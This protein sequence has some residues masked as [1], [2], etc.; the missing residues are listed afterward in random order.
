MNALKLS[1][2]GTFPAGTFP[3]GTFAED[4]FLLTM[5]FYD[6]PLDFIGDQDI[7]GPVRAFYEGKQISDGEWA[8]AVEEHRRV[9]IKHFLRGGAMDQCMKKHSE[10]WASLVY[11]E[12][13]TW[14]EFDLR[15]KFVKFCEMYPVLGGSARS[16]TREFCVRY[17]PNHN[18]N[19][20]WEI[21]LVHDVVY[22]LRLYN[23]GGCVIRF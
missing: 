4:F 12:N 20:A 16:K 3:T 18:T 8:Q 21:A 6:T 13:E 15:Y 22:G 19:R 23:R 7:V 9:Y 5:S 1:L 2:T 17:S 11:E 14:G 10:V